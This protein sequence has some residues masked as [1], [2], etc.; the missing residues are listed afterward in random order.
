M[1]PNA[2]SWFYNDPEH[3]PYLLQER[4][5]LPLWA[6]GAYG[7]KFRCTRA[8]PPFQMEGRWQ[9]VPVAIEWTP[10]ASLTLRAAGDAAPLVKRLSH[11]LGLKPTRDEET[12][13]GE[14]ITEWVASGET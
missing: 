9:D 3:D 4:V 12:P 14:Q 5:N 8:E 13:V 10:N 1:A 11:V 2:R 6:A 7:V